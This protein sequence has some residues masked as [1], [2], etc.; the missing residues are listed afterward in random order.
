MAMNIFIKRY[1]I[2]IAFK[3][4]LFVF[5]ALAAGCKGKNTST[6]YENLDTLYADFVVYLK[7]GG[8]DLKEYCFRI[9]PDKGTVAYMERNNVSYRGVPDKLK[10]QK[11]DVSI[12][13]EKY[14]E[15]VVNFRERLVAQGQ[16][17]DLVY[18]G[19]EDEEEEL[20]DERLNVMATETFILMRSGNDT[21]RCKLGEMFNYGK[22]WKSFASPKLGW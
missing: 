12:I 16:L 3:S 11:L 22:K 13:G 14:Y 15:S 8:N 21:I 9:C 6:G 5:V 18:I 10:E 2:S 7:K 1:K 20:A 4:V 17:N 19:Q